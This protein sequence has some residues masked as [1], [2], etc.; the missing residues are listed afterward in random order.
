MEKQKI[1]KIHF[2]SPENRNVNMRDWGTEGGSVCVCVCVCVSV[3]AYLCVC[4]WVFVC[5]FM[6][7]CGYVC[8]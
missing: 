2:K 4:L 1:I 7:M 8:V 3:C 6:C 5:M